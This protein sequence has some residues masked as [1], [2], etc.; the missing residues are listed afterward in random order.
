MDDFLKWAHGR[1]SD[2]D[3]FGNPGVVLNPYEEEQSEL[4]TATEEW[5]QGF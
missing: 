5:E 1:T 2:K 4:I 3:A